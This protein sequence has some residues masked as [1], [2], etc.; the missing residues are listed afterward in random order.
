M[1][2]AKSMAFYELVVNAKKSAILTAYHDLFTI[3]LGIGVIMLLASIGKIATG[4]GRSLV[5]KQKRILLPAPDSR[6]AHK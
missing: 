4:K 5:Q 3:M 1:A 6:Q 2:K